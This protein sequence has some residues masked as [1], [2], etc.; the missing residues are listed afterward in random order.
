VLLI[1]GKREGSFYYPTV[2]AGARPGMK[3]VD[4]EVFGPVVTVFTYEDFDEA[5]K[6]V[7][8]SRYG[9]QAGIYTRD[10]ESTRRAFSELDV[11][12]VIIGDV[13][14][15]RV[16]RMPYGGVKASGLGREGLRYSIREM[17]EPK[18]LVLSF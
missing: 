15:F 14:T 9:L 2:I 16:D 12:G 4:E 17:C 7:N 18:L 11:G 13:P 3:V 1:G 10:L 5:L 6:A 8:D